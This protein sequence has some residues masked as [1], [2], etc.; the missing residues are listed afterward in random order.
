MTVKLKAVR[1]R[2]VGPRFDAPAESAI[3]A[4]AFKAPG[5]PED[6]AVD[7]DALLPWLRQEAF[8]YDQDPTVRLGDAIYYVPRRAEVEQLLERSLLDRREWLE[9]RH[10]CDDFAYVL[11]GEA[12]SHAYDAP[13]LRFGLCL[14]I[15]WGYFDWARG[16]HAINWALTSDAGLLLI[17]PQSD[18]L[19]EPYRCSGGVDLILV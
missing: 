13:G 16:Y 12:S 6:A 8:K 15:A 11:K 7:H 4:Q 10:D 14:G 18:E 5:G 19:Y 1:G 3:T 9:E 2:L 17:E